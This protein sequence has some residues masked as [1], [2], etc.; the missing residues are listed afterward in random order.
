MSSIETAA[1]L[2]ILPA[3]L[4]LAEQEKG[5]EAFNWF[6]YA[7]ETKGDSY[8]I[9]KVGRPYLK[10]GHWRMTAALVHR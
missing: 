9:M 4:M 10:N 5:S 1:H 7:A 3:I 6:Y 8:A 2:D